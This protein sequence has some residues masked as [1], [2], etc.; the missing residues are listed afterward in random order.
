MCH[1]LEVKIF[2][3]CTISLNLHNNPMKFSFY[4]SNLGLREVKGFAQVAQLIITR[5]SLCS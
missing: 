2:F 5:A 3:T 4:M 1:V